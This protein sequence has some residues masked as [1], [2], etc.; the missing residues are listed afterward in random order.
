VISSDGWGEFVTAREAADALDVP[1]GTV[2]SWH[3]RGLLDARGCAATR[4][5]PLLY[6]WRDVLHAER[7][8]RR[9][10][11]TARRSRALAERARREAE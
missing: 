1:V 7:I 4:G 2:R 11:P 3:E 10:D 6:A 5:R 8:A 9:R